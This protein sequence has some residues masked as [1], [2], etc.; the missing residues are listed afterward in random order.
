MGT[1]PAIL[2]YENKGQPW[3]MNGKD[4]DEH[5]DCHEFPR[6]Y[7]KHINKLCNECNKMCE[8]GKTYKEIKSFIVETGEDYLSGFLL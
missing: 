8:E 6:K 5:I 3:Y 1:V 2:V 7:S 4:G